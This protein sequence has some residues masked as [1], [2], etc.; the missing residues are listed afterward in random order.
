MLTDVTAMTTS[1]AVAMDG[2]EQVAAAGEQPER[3]DDRAANGPC[4]SSRAA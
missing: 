4:R 1:R 3:L 2:E